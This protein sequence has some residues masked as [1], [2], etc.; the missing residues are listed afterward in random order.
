M[1]RFVSYSSLALI[2]VLSGLLLAIQLYAQ[3][4][5]TLK[6]L[7]SLFTYDTCSAPCWFGLIPGESTSADVE[8]LFSSELEANPESLFTSLLLAPDPRGEWDIQTGYVIDGR[9]LFYWRPLEH[10]TPLQSQIII[11]EN[12]VELIQIEFNYS[13]TLTQTLEALGSPD[14]IYY[15]IDEVFPSLELIYVAERLRVELE[16]RMGRL[17]TV[18]ELGENFKVIYVRYYSV[19]SATE[20]IQVDGN[21]EFG[22]RLLFPTYI[23]ST[24]R[25]YRSV[26]IEVLENWLVQQPNTSCVDAFNQLTE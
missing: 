14:L 16:H 1:K 19:E 13:Y 10:D 20:P 25:D 7:R 17:C 24:Y 6:M 5:P 22:S 18:P 12:V 2:I 9:Y 26:P 23:L 21:G 4:E 3:D 15:S 8:A 11:R